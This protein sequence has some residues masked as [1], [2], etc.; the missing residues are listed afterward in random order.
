[1][2]NTG[3]L[4]P[5]GVVFA[6]HCGGRGVLKKNFFRYANLSALPLSYTPPPTFQILEI[7]LERT[8]NLVACCSMLCSNRARIVLESQLEYRLTLPGFSSRRSLGSLWAG[9][10]VL[11]KYSYVNCLGLVSRDEDSSIHLT[12]DEMHQSLSL[13]VS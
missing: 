12:T 5:H 1:M 2:S 7:S 10:T 8:K 11:E 13:P 3:C 6:P 4:H 9:M